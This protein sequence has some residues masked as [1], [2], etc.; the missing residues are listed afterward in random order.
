MVLQNLTKRERE[1]KQHFCT[2]ENKIKYIITQKKERNIH[3][4]LFPRMKMV[5]YKGLS[6]TSKK[7]YAK[8]TSSL[9]QQKI[10]KNL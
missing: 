4:F 8:V 1:R 7:C 9:Q 5:E 3:S 2:P 10:S 6:Y